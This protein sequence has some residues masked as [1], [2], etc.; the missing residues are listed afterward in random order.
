MAFSL[1]FFYE[2]EYFETDDKFRMS[3]RKCCVT[4][5]F[6]IWLHW[7]N[8]FISSIMLA[9]FLVLAL[10]VVAYSQKVGW[11]AVGVVCLYVAGFGIMW[12]RQFL[13]G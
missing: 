3:I 8:L 7:G 6:N 5:Q 10:V 13:S 11:V 2:N 9:A 12:W 4:A 1:L